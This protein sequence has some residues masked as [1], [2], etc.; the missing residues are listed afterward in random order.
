FLHFSSFFLR[1]FFLLSH[2]HLSI[3]H[4][5]TQRFFSLPFLSP[6][7]S[8]ITTRKPQFK[9][10][11]NSFIGLIQGELHRQARLHFFL[12]PETMAT[13]VLS[14]VAMI[15]VLFL[16]CHVRVIFADVK[17]SSPFLRLP[18]DAAREEQKV[19]PDAESSSPPASCPVKCF[20]ADP[21]CG[22][23][24]VTYWCG[25]AEAECAGVKV[26]KMGF[27]EVGNGVS[28]PLSGQ[29]LLLVHIVWLIVLGFSV[30]FGLF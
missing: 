24:G 15:A 19:C 16:L 28:T 13:K 7:S 30:F 1:T 3:V 11:K 8:K 21:V 5:P 20:R 2:S 12:C 22:I 9:K 27:C 26:A 29:A 14:S 4:L 17:S 6:Y 18:S 23:D 10:K 25:C